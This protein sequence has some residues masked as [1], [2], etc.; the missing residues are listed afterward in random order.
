MDEIKSALEIAME[1]VET[2]G[3]P[4]EEE[5]L[6][7][8]YMPEGS[9]IAARYMV[10]DCNL[11]SELGNYD[12][13]SRKYVIDGAS[14]VLIRNIA[15]PDSDMAKRKNKLAM[16]GLKEIKSDRVGLENI[17]GK[18][19]GIFEHYLDTGEQQ[20]RQAY[21]SLKSEFEAQVKQ[22]LQQ[23]LGS[24]MGMQIDVEKQP[25]FQNEWRKRQSQL[26]SEYLNLL[27][28]LKQELANL[29]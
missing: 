1:K 23:Q 27:D 3:E 9:K 16:D 5:R 8:K 22:A 28:E 18:I 4:T 11:T 15:L 10:Q 19:R 29:S 6:R 26:D 13:N 12:E 14:E 24:A 20:R 2:L 25:Q 21:I 7:W 17:Y